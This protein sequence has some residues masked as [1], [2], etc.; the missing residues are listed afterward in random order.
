ML[1]LLD[2]KEQIAKEAEEEHPAAGGLLREPTVA[3][4]TDIVVCRDQL[5]ET[6]SWTDVAH[7]IL[8]SDVKEILASNVAIPGKL[9]VLQDEEI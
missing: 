2:S 4:R 9:E 6:K 7:E 1:D 5:Q 8:L 3:S